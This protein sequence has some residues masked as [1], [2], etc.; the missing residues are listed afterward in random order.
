MGHL[1][2]ANIRSLADHYLSHIDKTR[3]SDIL[4]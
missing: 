1:A 2:F 4:T 3:T